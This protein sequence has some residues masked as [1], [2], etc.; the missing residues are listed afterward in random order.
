MA[1]IFTI[2]AL[3]KIAAQW[4]FINT[5]TPPE[6]GVVEPTYDATDAVRLRRN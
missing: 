4:D 2:A 3:L 5:S 1:T 6:E